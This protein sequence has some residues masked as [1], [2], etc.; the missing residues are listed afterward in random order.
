MRTFLVADLRIVCGG[1]DYPEE[2]NEIR[3]NALIFIAIWPVGVPLLYVLC[4]LPIR[5]KLRQRKQT[6]WVQA[7]EFLHQDYKPEFFWWEIVTLLQRLVLSG[8]VLLFP[9]ELDSWR[10]FVG[11]LFAV[12]Y[13]SL[14]QY[15]QPY[16]SDELNKL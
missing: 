15:V 14:L 12:G 16:R 10:L 1:N 13:L 5:K 3:H 7:T 9:I 6:R 11:L 8:F 4:L 2:Y